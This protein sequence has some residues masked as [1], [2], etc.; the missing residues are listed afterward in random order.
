MPFA[1]AIELFILTVGALPFAALNRQTFFERCLLLG[2]NAIPMVCFCAIFI[3]LA[4]TFQTVNELRAYRAQD[5]AGTVIAIALLRELGPVTVSLAWCA[6]TAAIMSE[7]SQAFRDNTDEH[8][9]HHFVFTN[10]L[11][12]LAMSVPLSV[13]GLVAGFLAGALLAPMVGATSTAD[14]LEASRS[15]IKN[16]DLFVYFIKVILI[17]PT[18]ATFIGCAVGKTATGQTSSAARA[19]SQ[20][21]IIATAVNLALTW[22]LYK[23]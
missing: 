3:S 18:I 23:Q 8:F 14:F 9:V 19:V 10:W 6:R 4:L 15:A 21:F 11:A 2:E 20:M 12:S 1:K 5:L 7:G 13:F 22:A 17:N 16:R